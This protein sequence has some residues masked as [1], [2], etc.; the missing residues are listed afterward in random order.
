MHWHEWC[1]PDRAPSLEEVAAFVKNGLWARARD[2]IETSFKVTPRMEYS[3]C[4]GQK[5]WNI[6][7]KKS[8]RSLCTL[9]PMDGY[10]ISLVVI[11]RR[12][13][14]HAM[15]QIL[16]LLG[17]ETQTLYG[18]T[19]FSLGGRWLMMTVKDEQ[20]LHDLLSLVKVRAE[21]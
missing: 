2:E 14:E 5:G 1:G 11:G 18:R 10:F 9:Y 15:P 4:S 13:E 21:A 17:E 7:Y 20:S 16:P 12:E 8:G 3:G 19:P 6:K